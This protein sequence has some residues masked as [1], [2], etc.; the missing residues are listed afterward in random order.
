V[1]LYYAA[2][3]GIGLARSTD[4]L[5]FV[6]AGSPVLAAAPGIGWESTAPRAPSVALLPDGSWRMFYGAG[7]AIGEA[8][9]NDG[10]TWERVDADP[11]TP[12]LDAVLA[13]SAVGES[14]LLPGESAPFDAGQVDDPMVAVRTTAAGRL[15]LR[16][17]YTGYDAPL[18]A[19]TRSSA[20]GFAARYGGSGPLT[21]QPIPVYSVGRHEAAP[22]LFEYGG[23]S[24]LYVEEDE[25]SQDRAHPYPAIAAACA[26]TTATLA[27][28]LPFPT[29]P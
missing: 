14:S 17:L 7:S 8:R 28:Q 2:A 1:W 5:T 13:P 3:G 12:A 15:Q 22:A 11:S 29:G 27:P 16:V 24:M 18:G 10:S 19:P 26:P 25:T 4:G 23:G 20:I 6:K 9:S 21:R